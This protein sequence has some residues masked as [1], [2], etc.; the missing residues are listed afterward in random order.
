LTDLSESRK[1]ASIARIGFPER[2]G[3]SKETPRGGAKMLAGRAVNQEL[4][5][6]GV[7]V[8]LA[9]GCDALE[10]IRLNSK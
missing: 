2:P 4:G 6:A 9:R 8:R 1:L 5:R 7:K 3:I 10:S